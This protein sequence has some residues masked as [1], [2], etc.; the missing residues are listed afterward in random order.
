M[1]THARSV[2]VRLALITLPAL[3]LAVSVSARRQQGSG[4]PQPLAPSA[5]AWQDTV[6]IPSYQ[7]GPPDP[8]PPFDL[9]QSGRF[10]YPYTLRTNLSDKRVDKAWRAL[11]LENEYLKCLVLPDL[12]GHLYS[13]TDKRNGQ[14]MFYANPSIKLAAI[15]YR[16]AWA[17][18]GI[19]FNFPVSHNWMTVSPVD[20]A[21]TAGADGSASVWVGNTDRPYGMQWRVQL[22][23][24]PGR[25]VLEQ[26]T[27][28]YN[29][30]DARHRFY[31]WTNAGVQ[32]W[33][34][35]KI[36]YPTEFTAS[37]GFTF[38]DTW[39]IDAAG[40]DVS[41]VGNHKYGPVSRF[42]HGSREPFMGVYH[43]STASGVVHY[44][45]PTDLPAKKF[46]S[47]SSDADGLDWRRALSDN[48]SAYVEIQAGPFR[49]Q[50]TYGFLEPQQTLR[51]SEYW[52]PMLDLGG[53]SRATADALLHLSRT[54]EPGG[55]VT[56]NVALN[57]LRPLPASRLEV[58]DGARRVLDERIDLSP[59]STSRRPLRGQTAAG[60]YTV[61]VTDASGAVVLE[62][63]EGVY[64]LAPRSEIRPGAQPVLQPPPAGRGTD[65]DAMT[66]GT[67]QELG[68]QLLVALAT[69]REA[70]KRH[71]ES[72]PLLRSAGRLMVALK[73]YEEAVPLLTR[74][75]ARVSNDRE[76]AYYLAHAQAA[77][78]RTRAS[79]VNFEI[80][81][82]YGPH[83]A[84][85]L[86]NLA[87]TASR[88]GA[89]GDALRLLAAAAEAEPLG[90]RTG[91]M[92]VAL[93]RGSGRTEEARR[94]LA[95][96]RAV[97]PTNSMLR[98]E[99]G[100]LG[101][102]DPSLWT[103][104]AGDPERVLE[105]AVDYMTFGLY[106]D[107]VAILAA[108]YPS[109]PSVVSEPGMP[110]PDA[111]PLIAY[112][113][114]YCQKQ[115]ARDGAAD[116]ARAS[117]MPT[118]YVFPHRPMSITVLK[119]AV[120]VNPQDATAHFLLGSLY[121]SGGMIEPAMKAWE[122]ARVLNPA[123]PTLHRNMGYTLLATG[124]VDKA[125][126]V[127]REGMTHDAA[128]VGIYSGL[129]QALTLA[130]RPAA[131][132]ADALLA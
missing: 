45:P 28:L 118:T 43:P 93:L 98:F 56:L 22:T 74:A 26:Q 130:G 88:G 44:S 62:H 116:Y 79:T 91:A 84:A 10:N 97:D 114:G 34:D 72:L 30:S 82:Q 119:D 20:F 96:W 95:H 112:Y 111:Y 51:F 53:L 113:R 131:E 67:E 123:I 117:R 107:A 1:L 46:W 48:N 125:I 9:F 4:Q 58:T 83:R 12:G 102:G 40:H 103:H 57:V 108:E 39:P 55:A 78:G 31:W 81:Q 23:L 115:L 132:R 92:E 121:L 25:A 69:Y 66:A 75:L 2:Q 124:D 49:N 60:T 70:L 77:L 68:G 90:V 32:V 13:C 11:W 100:R 37:H 8:N 61:R 128:N 94:R 76:T 54:P 41:I 89:G 101:T 65:G 19:E 104:L 59:A 50:E 63:T 29:R 6:T 3:A 105:I 21:T 42:A 129:D 15:A 127:F 120:A 38:V 86:L 110:R 14:Q 99:A 16:G 33:D 35:T 85:A 73:Q 80:A 87:A 109:G 122:R 24:R 36:L 71:P 64:D 106:A 7:D 47:W 126:G 52:M 17:A 18:F 27:A 5:R